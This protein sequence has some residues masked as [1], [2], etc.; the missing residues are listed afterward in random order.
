M[1]KYL[2][3]FRLSAIH[4]IRNYKALIG[5][6]IF[7]VTCLVI[8]QHLWKIAAM[9]VGVVSLNPDELLW[10]TAFNQWLLI[11]LPDVHED[12][13]Y[14]LRSGRLA[15]LL[16]RPISYLIATFFEALGYLCVHLA[17]LGIVTFAFTWIKIGH[18][19]FDLRAFPLLLFIGLLAGIVGI[20]FHMIVGISAFW[21]HNVSAFHWVW[22]KLLFTLGGL[23]LPLT[24]YPAFLAKIAYCTP[25]PHI[26]GGRSALAIY[27]TFTNSLYVIGSLFAW[28][29]LGTFCLVLLYR[30]GLKI[31]D[32]GGG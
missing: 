12:M 23:M 31:V 1:G 8:F 6:S 17:V 16:P 29:L 21:V 10:F 32:I 9:R 13:E 5:S 30:R 22:E 14:D 18:T 4:S 2:T 24:V 27:F 3:I 7:L 28:G 25:F 19:S 26:L 11:S 15:Y 20:V